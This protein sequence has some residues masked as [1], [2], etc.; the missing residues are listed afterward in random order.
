MEGAEPNGQARSAANV[1]VAPANEGEKDAQSRKR[2]QKVRELGSHS[3]SLDAAPVRDEDG[4]KGEDDE[5]TR[6][7]IGRKLQRPPSHAQALRSLSL[8]SVSAW[9]SISRA[10]TAGLMQRRNGLPSSSWHSWQNVQTP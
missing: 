1:S 8:A 6:E 10:A 4:E 9:R 3:G 5:E 7:T 2:E